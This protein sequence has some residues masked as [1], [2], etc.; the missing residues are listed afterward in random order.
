MLSYAH[1]HNIPILSADEWLTFTDTRRDSQVFDLKWNK[2]TGQLK[3]NVFIPG[4][5]DTGLAM[6]IPTIFNGRQ[7]SEL[8]ID[9]S[10]NKFTKK[11]VGAIS[12]AIFNLHP[13][14]NQVEA[15]YGP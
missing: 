11:T 14:S 9:G 15:K 10:A 1:E 6:M 13:G 12:Y 7:I 4:N 5:Q 2:T 3:F 8:A